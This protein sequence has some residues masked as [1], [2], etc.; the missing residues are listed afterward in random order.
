MSPYVMAFAIPIICLTFLLYV[1]TDRQRTVR[2]QE[3]MK[4]LTQTATAILALE[5]VR[6]EIILQQSA[7]MPDLFLLQD[8]I[9]AHLHDIQEISSRKKES[10]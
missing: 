6:A 4:S 7:G 3:L 1:W 8:I 10:S 2:H 5:Q 9:R